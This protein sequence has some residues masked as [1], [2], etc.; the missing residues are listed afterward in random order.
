MRPKWTRWVYTQNS[1]HQIWTC[2]KVNPTKIWDSGVS[3]HWRACAGRRSGVSL[4]PLHSWLI[5]ARKTR[6]ISSFP[7]LPQTF[8]QI[9]R[10]WEDS[11][12]YIKEGCMMASQNSSHQKWTF[13]KVNPII[14]DRA[15]EFWE[16]IMTSDTSS[17][18]TWYTEGWNITNARGNE[19]NCNT[20]VMQNGR[21]S[22]HPLNNK[23]HYH[24]WNAS[25]R[26]CK[27]YRSTVTRLLNEKKFNA[28]IKR[29]CKLK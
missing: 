29:R 23:I 4:W 27:R 20:N 19:S 1:A 7:P 16:A 18:A 12:L 3:Y 22:T 8:I 9:Q 2:A 24:P 21:G 6:N 28:Q 10:G 15:E 26:V 11:F 13:P 17:M 5:Q 14:F 25:D